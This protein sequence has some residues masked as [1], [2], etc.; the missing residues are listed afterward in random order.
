MSITHQYPNEL[1]ITLT[2][3]SGTKSVLNSPHN[4]GYKPDITANGDGP[5]A[6]SKFISLLELI[7]SLHKLQPSH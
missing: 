4:E 3:P 1:E 7:F 5:Y 6:L 2:A